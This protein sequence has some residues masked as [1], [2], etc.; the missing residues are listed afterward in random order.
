L[1][2]TGTNITIQHPESQDLDIA[3]TSTGAQ[4]RLESLADSGGANAQYP[5]VFAL[6]WRNLCMT[7]GGI[8]AFAKWTALV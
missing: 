1:I 3:P 2:Q 4:P 5:F 7:F 6:H 8:R